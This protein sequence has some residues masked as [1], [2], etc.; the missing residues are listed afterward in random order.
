M[1]EKKSRPTECLV[2]CNSISNIYSALICG[3]SIGLVGGLRLLAV[4]SKTTSEADQYMRI[5]I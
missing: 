5:F 2:Y 3:D 4:H 1:A